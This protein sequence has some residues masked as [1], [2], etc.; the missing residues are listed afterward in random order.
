M[1]LERL[2]LIVVKRCYYNEFLSGVKTIEYRRHKGQFNAHVFY[3]GRRVRIASNYD[4]TP[5]PSLTAI[6]TRFEVASASVHPEMRD[7]YQ[8][9]QATD[10]IAVIHLRVETSA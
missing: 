8:E 5:C 1:A 3:P 2:P 4:L 10:E 9:L 6:A 7:F